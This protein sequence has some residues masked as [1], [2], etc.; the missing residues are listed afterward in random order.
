MDRQSSPK[1]NSGHSVG[2]LKWNILSRSSFP[3]TSSTD[4]SYGQK[5]QQN[6]MHEIMWW[7]HPLLVL[8]LMHQGSGE[9]C[10]SQWYKGENRNKCSQASVNFSFK[11]KTEGEKREEKHQLFLSS[12][13][14][15]FEIFCLAEIQKYN[16]LGLL[17]MGSLSTVVGFCVLFLVLFLFRLFFFNY[18]VILIQP[19]KSHC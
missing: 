11:K 7:N 14:G 1:R 8:I 18:N 16:F 12:I 15:N 2:F 6:K 19:H 17:L 5:K 3:P 4:S 10:T 9:C 13:N